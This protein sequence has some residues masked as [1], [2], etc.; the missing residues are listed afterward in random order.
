VEAGE[1]RKD[2]QLAREMEVAIPRELPRAEAIWLA[3]DFVQEQFV[4]RG[5]V[6]DLN[7]HWD[8]GVDGQAKPHLHVLLTMRAVT[9][10]GFG[11]KVR[12]WNSAELYAG[13]RERWVALANERLAASGYDV[14]ID[15]RSYAEQG[16]RLEPQNKIGPAGARRAERGEDAQRAAEHAAIARRNGERIAADPLVV[17]DALT[18]QHSTFT[19]QDLARWVSRHTADA[20]QFAQVLAKVEA[21]PELVRLGA[22][23]RGRLRLTTRE[24]VR[25]E[26]GMERDAL[27]LA[28]RVTHGVALEQRRAT[29]AGAGLGAEQ[30][31]AFGHVTR[32]RDLV[33]V[34]GHAGT[35]KS[36]M[37]G[38]A[39]EAW[40]AAG[41]RVRGAA[42]S[43]IAAEG[44]EGG[45]GIASRTLA[46]LEWSWREGRDALTAQDVLV[47]DEAGMVGSRQMAR[48]LSA[49][50]QA[51][52]KAVLVGD[53]GQLQ[54]I[55]AGAAFR[56]IVERHGAAEIT[57][58]RRQRV[59]WQREATR[60]LATG[61]T[62]AALGRYEAAGMVQGHATQAEAR[63]ALVVE[64]DL[65]RR[66]SPHQSR[67]I[68]TGTRAE[69]AEL[70]G[71]ARARLRLAGEL[72]AEHQVATERG[73]RAMAAGDRVMFLRNERGLGADEK[74]RGGIAV[75]NGTLG[76]VLAVE[77][78]GERLTVRLDRAGGA[79]GGTDGA[80]VVT[81]PVREYGHLDW[82][83]AATTHKGQGMTV[84][85]AHVLAGGFMD[86]HAAYV[87]LTRHRD[88]V[89][90]H[91]SHE[92][93]GD[94]AGLLRTLGRDRAKDTSLDYG[95][96][97]E[98]SWGPEAAYAERRGVVPAAE[99]AAGP[100]TAGQ[101]AAARAALL[102]NRV[103]A[104][105]QAGA[106]ALQAH[107]DQVARRQAAGLGPAD[108][109]PW[110]QRGRAVRALDGALAAATR[111]VERG[112][113]TLERV[114]TAVAELPEALRQAAE[115]HRAAAEAAAREAQA[116]QQAAQVAA[117]GVAGWRERYA[118][119]RRQRAVEAAWDAQ[120]RG[121]AERWDG[122]IGAV[123]D[124]LPGVERDPG[125]DGAR[126][127]LIGFGQD[128]RRHPEAAR[129]L[130]ERP[131][132]F[133]ME[134]RPNLAQVLAA[135][136]PE[137]A[138]AAHVDAW[139]A[140]QRAELRQQA[141]QEAA[142]QRAQAAARPRSSF[143][144]SV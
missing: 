48:V 21:S 98:P 22:D 117:A 126:A 106:A 113:A 12:E 65:E 90:L 28:G 26:R 101:R 39:R 80:P 2:A 66:Q 79:G 38:M 10:A 31:V 139:A 82:G 118:A 110:F 127:A 88:G 87:A 36:A 137:R 74:G 46:S 109:Q 122:L 52:A 85:R 84:D 112:S 124:A 68:L 70:N 11:R 33:A 114:A 62:A 134:G 63:T 104:L 19:R 119:E 4:N 116:R 69:A 100:G 43:G 95:P 29:A 59:T 105:Q 141:E 53:P 13:V 50:R 47:V 58:V 86:R 30:Q 40:E 61:K 7:V 143:G 103:G 129:A 133:G 140:G 54:A 1:K 94:R 123:K 45:S 77:A 97:L 111:A 6:A 64:W 131:G 102:L 115:R 51:G 55:E 91:W 44:L 41:Y 67:M 73:V 9:A 34:V 60:E 37:L 120:A 3:R 75:K 5:M 42:L 121:L 144:P 107:T 89:A 136:D 24:M 32:A 27:A 93:L 18:R 78:Q 92:E 128:L 49:V 14:R 72:G 23:G 76:T 17:L 130:R 56:A 135:R 15:H 142:R 71:L 108:L 35:G 132:E 125:L 99:A 96:G 8:V 138:V 20:E 83:Y 25:V 57:E 16:I 81:F